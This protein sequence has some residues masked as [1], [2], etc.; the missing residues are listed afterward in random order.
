[1]NRNEL[2]NLVKGILV[3]PSCCGDLKAVAQRWLDAI[4]TENEKEVS[5]LLLAELKDDVCT[6]DQTIPFFESERATA[7][8]GEERAKQLASH[9]HELKAS[10]AK[11]CDCPA[12]ALGAKILDDPS[13]LV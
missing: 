9:A 10:G 11:W 5:A 12:C 7:I 13:A 1:M 6:L 8:F 2:I 3:A 4:G